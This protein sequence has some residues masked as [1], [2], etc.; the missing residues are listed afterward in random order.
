MN[1]TPTNPTIQ[2]YKAEEFEAFLK[3]I[4]EGAHSHWID[5]AEA[6]GVNQDT[7]TSWKSHPR[8][9]QAINKGITNALNQ[10]ELVGKRDWR[11]WQEKLKM[12]GINPAVKS[13]IKVQGDPV[14]TLL[15]KYKVLEGSDGRE[16]D[17][18][19]SRPSKSD[20]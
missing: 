16:D 14:K 3:S 11:M 10:M 9:I 18:S 8:A 2:P 13:E 17:G 15:E 7:I 5:I 12:L 6:I 19:V 1:K 20:S 4:E